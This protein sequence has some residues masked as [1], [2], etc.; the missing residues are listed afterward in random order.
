MGVFVI[1]IIGF[2]VAFF[3]I[4]I[5]A[6]SM[7]EALRH[8][9]RSNKLETETNDVNAK[10]KLA[11]QESDFDL[12]LISELLKKISASTTHDA[13]TYRKKI[14]FHALT[15]LQSEDRSGVETGLLS[16]MA[17]GDSDLW[18]PLS[19][20]FQ[21]TSNQWSSDPDIQGLLNRIKHN[22]ETQAAGSHLAQ[23]S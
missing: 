6:L 12:H 13:Y 14:L 8:A 20:A 17:L 10:K 15:M 2:I 5:G 16:L 22:W 9:K 21:E 4:L 1:E 7:F 18:I 3:I 11:G 23:A 19:R